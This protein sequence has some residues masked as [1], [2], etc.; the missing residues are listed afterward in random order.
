MNIDEL[1]RAELEAATSTVPAVSPAPLGDVTR[2]AQRRRMVTRVGVAAAGVAVSVAVVGVTLVVGRVGVTPDAAGPTVTP[3]TN[4]AAGGGVV[5]IAGEAFPVD[6]LVEAFAA[7]PMYFGAPA[8][9]PGFDTTLLGGELP[10]EFGQ[11][12]V[13]DPDVLDGPTVYVGEA[14]DLS[15]FVNQ[16][17]AEGGP[18]KCLWMGATPQL[19]G[20]SG[21]FELN[22]PPSSPAAGPAYGAWLGVPEGTSVVVLR[23]GGVAVGWQQPV[24]GVALVRLPALGV[25]E[26]VALDGSGTDLGAVEVTAAPVA[27]PGAPLPGG[28]TTTLP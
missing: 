26:L 28:P 1:I 15:V 4:L 2:R 20:D 7:A 24:G 5:I 25:Y 3:V 6:G 9:P 8:P 19:C 18:G 22:Q 23:S 11:A 21:A 13:A 27:D 10:L 14:G 17:F 16:P 12:K